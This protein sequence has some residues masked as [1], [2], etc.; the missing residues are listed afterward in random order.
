M[1]G[2]G[3]QFCLGFP[4]VCILSPFHWFKAIFSGLSMVSQIMYK[5]TLKATVLRIL[6]GI[7]ASLNLPVQGGLYKMW[8]T[9]EELYLLI[10]GDNLNS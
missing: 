9:E 8:K 6:F 1:D 7:S 10:K 3:L 5:K 4:A 2:F